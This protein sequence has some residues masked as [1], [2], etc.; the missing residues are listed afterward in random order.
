[1]KTSDESILDKAWGRPSASRSAQQVLQ[2]TWPCLH[3]FEKLLSLRT[4][5]RTHS[6]TTS[7]IPSRRSIKGS[8]WAL[9]LFEN[10]AASLCA[11]VAKAARAI[12][13]LGNGPERQISGSSQAKFEWVALRPGEP[14]GGVC[15][16]S[17]L[18]H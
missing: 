16:S 3:A 2:S 10:L 13:K 11:S 7:F 5:S 1:M 14:K 8:Y 6:N 15:F 17:G 18:A 9:S 4:G 12:S